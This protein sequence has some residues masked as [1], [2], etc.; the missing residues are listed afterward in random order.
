MAVPLDGPDPPTASSPWY[1]YR[2][3]VWP[4]G[5][6]S[7]NGLFERAARRQRDVEIGRAGED[8]ANSADDT[9]DLARHDAD[10]PAIRKHDLGD[11]ARRDVLV[12]RLRHLE[13]GGKVHPDVTEHKIPGTRARDPHTPV[14]DHKGFLWFTV[15][16]GNMVGR[17]DP[18]TGN[19]ELREVP[20]P[21]ALPY[22]IAINSQGIPFFCEFGT[23]KLASID[24]RTLRIREYT[25]PAGARPRRLAKL[26]TTP[27]TT[28][29]TRAGTWPA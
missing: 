3:A 20:T 4:R 26:P 18:A 10:A 5:T 15:Q 8:L 24:P 23:N 12:T 6:G 9:V 13:L 27:S 28:R 16:R 17:L 14:F 11:P 7:S 29:T 2:S 25:L 1:T 19:I 21:D 22:G